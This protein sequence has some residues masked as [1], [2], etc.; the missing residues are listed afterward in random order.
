[1]KQTHFY[2]LIVTFF[3]IFSQTSLAERSCTDSSQMV[4]LMTVTADDGKP[5][6]FCVFRD[7]SYC[8][9][10]AYRKEAC[11]VGKN[12]W[13]EKKF[14]FKPQRYCAK[15]NKKTGKVTLFVC[16]RGLPKQ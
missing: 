14:L 13:P 15:A 4:K 6:S 12:R 8:E 11:H 1:M 10:G 9:E 2:L 3:M 7:K 16:F 5:Y